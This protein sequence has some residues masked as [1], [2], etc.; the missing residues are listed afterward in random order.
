M[1]PSLSPIK[2]GARFPLVFHVFSA[3]N[4]LTP[5]LIGV[6]HHRATPLPTSIANFHGF[7]A[8]RT[9]HHR[10]C[11]VSNPLLLQKL[12]HNSARERKKKWWIGD[13]VKEN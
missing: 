10:R 9:S 7:S 12:R 11:H 3:N 4:T 8:F 2:S 5:P 13:V 1:I 6:H